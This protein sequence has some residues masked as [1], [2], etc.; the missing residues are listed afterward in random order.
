MSVGHGQVPRDPSWKRSRYRS[1]FEISPRLRAEPTR[2]GVL[3]LWS[4]LRRR[5]PAAPPPPEAAPVTAPPPIGGP[6]G[7]RNWRYFLE[8]APSRG[9][10][11]VA[12]YTDAHVLGQADSGLG[13]YEVINTIAYP[14]D[15][16]PAMG[17]VLRMGWHVPEE[18]LFPSLDRPDTSTFHGGGLSDEIAALISLALGMRCVAGGTVREFDERKDPRG[19]PVQYSHK[20]PTL[21]T[22]RDPILPDAVPEKSLSE[23]VELLSVYPAVD[24]SQAIEV[25]RAAR[26]YQQG[27]WMAEADPEFA[28]LK[29]VSAV[30]TAANCWWRGDDSPE[31]A[32]RLAKPELAELLERHGGDELV[33]A[34][35]HLLKDQMQ[36]TKKFLT[37]LKVYGPGPPE[38]RPSRGAQVD[39]DRMK[40]HIKV[41]YGHRSKSL[42]AGTPFPTA[43]LDPAVALEEGGRPIERPLGSATATGDA[44]WTGA[45][46]PMLLHTFER[47][48]RLSILAWIR[49]PDRPKN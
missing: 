12:L 14:S 28:W 13:P 42:H 27:I 2:I 6:D 34:V 46:T 30:E 26:S 29:F 33:L 7:Y 10:W 8:G 24:E 21:Q 39:W 35:G 47:I 38:D 17:A 22:V 16:V 48:A 19:V 25:V 15:E 18:P 37:F 45:Q 32:L 36:A 1:C 11:E 49:E 40:D 5:R 4:I 3:K 41:V 9:S 43:M 44:V 31:T 23:L 20:R